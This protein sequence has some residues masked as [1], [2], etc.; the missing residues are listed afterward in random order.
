[1]LLVGLYVNG[2]KKVQTP[3]I[4]QNAN[5]E[6]QKGVRTMADKFT[7]AEIMKA[8]ECCSEDSSNC[9]ECPLYNKSGNCLIVLD[10]AAIDLINRK[11][12]MIDALI[13]GQ[14]TL[15]KAIA[16]RDAEIKQIVWERHMALEQIYSYGVGFCEDVKLVRADK[17]IPCDACAYDP[18]SSFNGN[19]CTMCPAVAKMDEQEGE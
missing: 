8:L 18:P 1:M 5:I 19:P 11:N 9:K 2:K 4:V 10:K 7:D 13:A 15:Q 3:A 17:L 6:N 14:E 12:E 16:E